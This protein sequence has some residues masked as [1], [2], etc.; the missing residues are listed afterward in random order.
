MKVRMCLPT[1]AE[2][3]YAVRART[4]TAYCSV[5]IT[6]TG[7]GYDQN[8][9]AVGWY[10]YNSGGMTLPVAQKALNAWGL[11]DMPGNVYEWCQDWYGSYG[12]ADTANPTGRR[13]EPPE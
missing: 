5:E 8:L 3:K 4:I 13:K 6:Q 2:W 1:E 10:T 9:D 11:Y 7:D 12:S